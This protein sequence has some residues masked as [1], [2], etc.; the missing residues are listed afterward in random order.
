MYVA[1]ES[2]GLVKGRA[3]GRSRSYLGEYDQNSL[4]N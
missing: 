1:N 4:E 3:V 2:E